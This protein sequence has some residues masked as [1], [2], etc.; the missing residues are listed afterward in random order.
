MT[1]TFLIPW[2]GCQSSD[3]TAPAI[4][5]IEVP[6]H[7]SLERQEDVLDLVDAVRHG[8]WSEFVSRLDPPGRVPQSMA[9]E[10]SGE[11]E[12]AGRRVVA[13]WG[14]GAGTAGSS[15]SGAAGSQRSPFTNDVP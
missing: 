12:A 6:A 13:S 11:S 5:D 14:S 9:R 4:C 15:T 7:V 10:A 1:I 8:E 3:E 2:I